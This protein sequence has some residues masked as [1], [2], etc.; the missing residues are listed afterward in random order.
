MKYK[1][2]QHGNKLHEGTIFKESVDF[3]IGYLYRNSKGVYMAL[4]LEKGLKN[5]MR[6]Y[7][8][9]KTYNDAEKELL[10]ILNDTNTI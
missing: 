8:R 2:V 1:V 9:S 6:T 7:L 5:N 4:N 10:E 3:R